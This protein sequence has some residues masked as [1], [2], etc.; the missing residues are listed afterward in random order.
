MNSLHESVLTFD[1]GLPGE[2][3]HIVIPDGTYEASVIGSVG[4]YFNGLSPRVGMCFL[5]QEDVGPERRIWAFYK[6]RRLFKQGKSTKHR[7]LNPEFVI[8]WR[9]R[10]AGD[11]VRLFPDRFS[12]SA[13]PTRIPKVHGHVLIETVTVTSDMEGKDRPQGLWSSKVGRIVGRTEV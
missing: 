8:G 2:D 6:V 3:H 13:L 4:F 1:A 9:A 10:L 7:I 11:L 12:A 5:I